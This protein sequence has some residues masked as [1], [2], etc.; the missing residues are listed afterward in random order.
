M[1]NRAMGG[2]SAPN[3]VGPAPARVLV[4]QRGEYPRI[5]LVRAFGTPRAS[6][7]GGVL[8]VA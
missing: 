2:R 4:R 6:S 5:L 1:H 7:L 3:L 8:P